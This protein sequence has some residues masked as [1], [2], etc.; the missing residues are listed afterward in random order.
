MLYFAVQR[1]RKGMHEINKVE[2]NGPPD[3]KMNI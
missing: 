3:K 2:D 1:P